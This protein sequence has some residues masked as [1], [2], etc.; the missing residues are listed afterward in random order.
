MHADLVKLFCHSNG[1]YT[2]LQNRI[3]TLARR[4]VDSTGRVR[5]VREPSDVADI[6]ADDMSL[7]KSSKTGLK[8]SRSQIEIAVSR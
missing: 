7:M 3:L 8:Q 5:R 2:A 6:S 4:H 1:L